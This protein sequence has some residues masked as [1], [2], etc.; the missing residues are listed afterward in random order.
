MANK[1]KSNKIKIIIL[2]VIVVLV[3]FIV[4]KYTGNKVVT[5]KQ[6]TLSVAVM[7]EPASLDPNLINGTWE[8]HIVSDMFTGLV[9]L[10]PTGETVPAMAT[11]WK[12]TD[13][14][15]VYTFNLR[16]DAKW[17]DGQPVTAGDF[18]FSFK[19]ELD[20]KTAAAYASLLYVIKGGEAYNTGKGSRD[21]VKVEAVNDNTLRI[22]LTNPIAY[23]PQM[24][25]HSVFSPLPEHVVEK[26][27]NAWSKPGNMVTNGA[28][29]LAEWKPKSYV[30]VVKNDY[31]YDAKDTKI[32]NIIYYTQ[33]DEDAVLKR[34]RANE[35]DWI[36]L[37]G[38]TQYDWI[39]KNLPGQAQ[40]APYAG[41]FYYAINLNDPKFKDPKVRMALNL[42]VDRD[43]ITSKIV[44]AGE[45]SAYNFIPKMGQYNPYV[46][47]WS[48]KSIKERQAMAKKLLA[49]AGYSDKKPLTI[50]VAYNTSKDNKD[51]SVAVAAMFNQV[52]IKTLLYNKEVSVHYADMR[53][54]NFEVGRAAWVADYLDPSNFLQILVGNSGNNNSGYHDAKFEKYYNMALS[55]SDVKTRM[56]Y[57]HD[58][59]QLF[60]DD[61]AIIPIFFY[62]SRNLVNP[63]VKGFA[64]NPIDV[65]LVRYMSLSN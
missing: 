64:T 29:K 49:E 61:N 11:S 32:N 54:G 63:R 3:F 9:E 24:L 58:A 17:S 33:D 40:V 18:V 36:T 39:V 21:D 8:A 44:K 35:I 46:P 45:V 2:A 51:I 59:E 43:F 48:T 7:G 28:Y 60:V 6:D 23:F 52:G 12:V 22:T 19:R 26:Y 50:T 5:N 42:A 56:K 53:A 16:K 4:H 13:G 25:V 37:F 55:S 1:P 65:H 20:P 47:N 15:K 31:F 10:S 41:V 38:S 27:G 34:Y 14:G 30:K 57:Y 62:V